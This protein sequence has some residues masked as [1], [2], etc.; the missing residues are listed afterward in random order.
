MSTSRKAREDSRGC[1]QNRLFHG[2]D[3]WREVSK[4]RVQ[5]WSNGWM[6]IVCIALGIPRYER[7]SAKDI[8]IRIILWLLNVFLLLPRRLRQSRTRSHPRCSLWSHQTRHFQDH[9]GTVSVWSLDSS[10]RAISGILWGLK[11]PMNNRRSEADAFSAQICS[12]VI[13]QGVI[14]RSHFDPADDHRRPDGEDC[15][16]FV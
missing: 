4:D 6:Y 7:I 15:Y 1:V 12:N 5:S 8:R 11:K 2:S 3:S 14:A 16:S 9:H 10:R 13:C